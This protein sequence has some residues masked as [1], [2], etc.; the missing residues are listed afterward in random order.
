MAQRRL[1]PRFLRPP[2]RER[3]RAAPGPTAQPGAQRRARS[4]ARDASPA[5]PI[6]ETYAP[7]DNSTFAPLYESS[8]HSCARQIDNGTYLLSKRGAEWAAPEASSGAAGEP[9]YR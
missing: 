3:G 4:P 5:A 8:V 2:A 1:A 9:P 7:Q 6:P